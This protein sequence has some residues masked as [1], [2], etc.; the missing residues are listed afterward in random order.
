MAC[1]CS[2][3]T[4]PSRFCW[5]APHLRREASASLL[6]HPDKLASGAAIRDS[7][8][9]ILR[10]RILP[11]DA[12]SHRLHRAKTAWDRIPRHEESKPNANERQ[13][14]QVWEEQ[15][16]QWRKA[17]HELIEDVVASLNGIPQRAHSGLHP[18]RRNS[19]SFIRLTGQSTSSGWKPESNCPKNML[20]S[21]SFL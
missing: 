15:R 14:N 8:Y 21:G 5:A 11:L 2:Q 3:Q 1:C 17:V 7:C 13:T 4:F 9:V 6:R 20:K 12:F 10:S 19:A 16:G 18:R